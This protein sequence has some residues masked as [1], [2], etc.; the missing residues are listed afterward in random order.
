MTTSVLDSREFRALSLLSRCNPDDLAAVAASV[1]ETVTLPEGSIICREG[2]TASKWWIVAEGLADVTTRGRYLST[3]GSGET[4]GELALLDGERRNATVIAGT[5]VVLHVVD[6]T[7]FLQV[8]NEHPGLS[9]ALLRQLA[10]ACARRT[11]ALSGARHRLPPGR[12]GV[13]QYRLRSSSGPHRTPRYPP[14]QPRQSIRRSR[15]TS[16]TR[17]RP[18]G[19]FATPTPFTTPN[20]SGSI[21]SRATKTC[22]D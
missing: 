13:S 18:I 21:S 14:L 5:D 2:E 11:I 9:I 12:S 3:I 8:L 20:R 1:T 6:G 19:R 4:I 10:D 16:P 15:G 7:S 17:M 22:I